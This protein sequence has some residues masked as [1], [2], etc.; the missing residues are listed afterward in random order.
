M[1]TEAIQKKWKAFLND[2]NKSFEKNR[3]WTFSQYKDEKN[4]APQNKTLSEK[5]LIYDEA[6]Y[7]KAKASAENEKIYKQFSH[8]FKCGEICNNKYY[9]YKDLGWTNIDFVI[10][11]YLDEIKGKND[12][13]IEIIP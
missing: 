11:F 4:F 9:Y 6:S 8:D 5:I 7:M 13:D 2:E 1:T 12:P 3:R 10:K